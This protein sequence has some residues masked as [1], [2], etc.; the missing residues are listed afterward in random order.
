[1]TTNWQEEDLNFLVSAA[2]ELGDYLQSPVLEWNLHSSRTVLT[3]GRVLLSKKR[4]ITIIN[5]NPKIKRLIELVEDT[6]RDK[7]ILWQRKIVLEIPRRMRVW[8]NVFMEFCDDGFD[9]SYPAQIVHRVILSLLETEAYSSNKTFSE[10][11]LNM[12]EKMKLILQSG[13]FIWDDQLEIEFP[14]T[15]FWFL[16]YEP[17]KG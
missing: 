6:I 13:K 5:S 8:E 1:L 4:L 2:K 16:Y 14:K 9:N 17:T 7:N 10:R 3:P 12:D 11:L 15:K